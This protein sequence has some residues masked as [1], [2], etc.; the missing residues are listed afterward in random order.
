MISGLFG[1]GDPADWWNAGYDSGELE[2]PTSDVIRMK[3]TSSC[4]AMPSRV[5]LTVR[6]IQD[7]WAA[8]WG[9]VRLRWRFVFALFL[10]LVGFGEG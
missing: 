5:V 9:S 10:A 1:T 8:M 4:G 2:L 3:P 7:G 6:A